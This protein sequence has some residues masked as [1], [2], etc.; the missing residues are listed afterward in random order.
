MADILLC[1]PLYDDGTK[2]AHS[3]AEEVRAFVEDSASHVCD[4]LSGA[5]AT[6]SNTEAKLREAV[7]CMVFYG[8]GTDDSLLPQDGLSGG[9]AV[10]DDSNAHLLSEK[11]VYAVACYSSKVL[12]PR[13]I[14]QGVAAYIG[15]RECFYLVATGTL[16]DWF[17][18]TANAV[19]LHLMDSSQAAVSCGEAVAHARGVYDDAYDYYKRG[20]GTNDPDRPIALSY[21]LWNRDSLT[22]SGE[23]DTVLPQSCT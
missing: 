2:I 12:G 8:H 17:K 23:A 4:D 15:Y 10:L 21:L 9:S 16:G 11:I 19:I 14:K 13:A 18:R 6:R 5:T 3:W 7:D 20:D 1:R 22:L